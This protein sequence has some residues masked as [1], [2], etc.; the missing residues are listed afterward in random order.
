MVADRDKQATTAKRTSDRWTVLWTEKWSKLK[1]SNSFKLRSWQTVRGAACIFWW[2]PIKTDPAYNENTVEGIQLDRAGK[3]QKCM[4]CIY[5]IGEKQWYLSCFYT[6]SSLYYNWYFTILTS[7]LSDHFDQWATAWSAVWGH[8]G[9]VLSDDDCGKKLWLQV[10]WYCVAILWWCICVVFME[11][12]K[13]SP[14]KW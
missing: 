10:L 8:L 7:F 12:Y 13:K 4:G 11:Y 1:K 6:M 2:M 14:Q 3:W 5:F 9:F